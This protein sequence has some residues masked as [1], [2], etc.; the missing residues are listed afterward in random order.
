MRRQSLNQI[1]QHRAQAALYLHAVTPILP[2]LCGGDLHKVFPFRGA[3]NQPQLTL[4]ICFTSIRQQTLP[5]VTQ[6]VMNLVDRQ[7]RRRRIVNRWRER[8]ARDIDNDAEGEHRI[9]FEGAFVAN[10]H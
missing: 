9:L 7:H 4:G 3:V 10:C 6:K 1:F 5:D 2:N 8:F